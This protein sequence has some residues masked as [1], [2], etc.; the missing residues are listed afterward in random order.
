[1]TYYDLIIIGGGAAGYAA[2][3]YAKRYEFSVLLI[4]GGRPGGETA[5]AG[6]IENYPG[7]EAI[8]GYEL[9]QKFRNHALKF[10]AVIQGGSVDK[11]AQ[12]GSRFKVT[13]GSEGAWTASAL[14]FAHGQARRRLGLPNEDALTGKGV[15]YCVTCD[16]PLYKG[17]TVG[18][19]GGGDASVKG[20]NLLTEYA[21]KV[22]LIVMLGQV[23]AEPINYRLMQSKG[24][25]VEVLYQT[26]VKELR[27]ENGKFAGVRLS[28]AYQGSDTL[29]LDGLFIEIGAVPDKTLPT[30]LGVALAESGHIH[31]DQ[32]MRTNVAGVFAAGDVT[33]ATGSFR[34]IVTAAAQGAIAATS[35]YEYLKIQ[36]PN[37]KIQN[38]S[39]N[40]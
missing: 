28:R 16:G 5:N 30:Q 6:L 15:S 18:I 32:F 27:E 35:A 37:S 12:E 2:A 7:F 4:E 3:L 24:D 39:N 25:T 20:A 22:F 21:R 36:N 9:Y 40:K 23:N 26:Q 8:D 14:I 31:V 19:V 34:Q 33:D 10:G 1:M 17:K 11:I 29:Q 38:V 13:A